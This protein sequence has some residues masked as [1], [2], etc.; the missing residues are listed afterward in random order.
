MNDTVIQVLSNIVVIDAKQ[1][2]IYCLLPDP[3]LLSLL[4]TFNW[5]LKKGMAF[6]LNYRKQEQAILSMMIFCYLLM[7]WCE[8]IPGFRKRQFVVRLIYKNSR[9]NLCT[10][11]APTRRKL[12]IQNSQAPY[13]Y[14]PVQKLPMT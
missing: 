13:L 2:L 5:D 6:S 12:I 7:T 4:S 14:T 1:K 10:V 3:P 8:A 11:Y 9:N